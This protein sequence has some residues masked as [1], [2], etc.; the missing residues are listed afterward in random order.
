V[1][2]K[3]KRSAK[4]PFYVLLILAG[5]LFVVTAFAYFTMAIRESSGSSAAQHGLTAF[6]SRHGLNLLIAELVVLGIATFG[7]I[8]TDEYWSRRGGHESSQPTDEP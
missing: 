3:E 2:A 7:A 4:N 1:P 6:V 8:G 5:V